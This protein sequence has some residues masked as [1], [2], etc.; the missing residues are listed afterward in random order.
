MT[1]EAKAKLHEQVD[2]THSY[3]RP[4]F[5]DTM[6]A[7]G[8]IRDKCKELGHLLVD[9]CPISRELSLA[10]TCLDDVNMKAIAALARFEPKGVAANVTS[11]PLPGDPGYE[12]PQTNIGKT[13]D[14]GQTS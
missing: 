1:D 9:V 4:D 3:H 13:F 8:Q 12:H 2:R 5:Q 11:H 6:D 10:L 7:M 14:S